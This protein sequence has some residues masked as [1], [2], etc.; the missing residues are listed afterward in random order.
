MYKEIALDPHCM[1]EFHYYALLK[2]AFGFE[3]GRYVIAPTKDWV[4][5]AYKSVKASNISPNKQKSVTN[6]LNKVQRDKSNTLIFLPR[7]RTNL[8]IQNGY[9][10][11]A[12]WVST[13]QFF[14]PFSA[15]V[16]ENTR[17]SSINYEQI[18][19]GNE[20]WVIPPTLWIDK[21]VRDIM[22]VVEPL[23]HVGKDLIIADPYFKL[24]GNTLLKA[25]LE[26]AKL[27]GVS[28]V[29]IVTS[30]ECS[31]LLGVFER[32]YK[33][34]LNEKIKIHYVRVPN[35]FIHDRYVFTDKAAIKAGQGFVVAPE[36]GLQSDHLSISLCGLEE[37]KDTRTR[38][39]QYQQQKPESCQLLG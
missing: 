4:R 12:E 34:L 9:T 23:F 37:Y 6:F 35:G 11:W 33:T 27:S 18:I 20:S 8:T 32:E 3:N 29:T 30:M 15:V 1:A 7:D 36:K 25:L 14:R 31:N 17:T 22:A 28:K 19:D 21:S 38:I 39:E 2:S 5:E 24:P 26:N 16:S 13:Q 10:N